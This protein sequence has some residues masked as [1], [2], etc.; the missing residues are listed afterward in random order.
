MEVFFE[1]AIGL[2]DN[3]SN[4]NEDKRSAVP[5][6]M[7]NKIGKLTIP[8]TK[9]ETGVNELTTAASL[10]LVSQEVYQDAAKIIEPKLDNTQC[11]FRR[12]CST[13]DQSFTLQNIFEKS[14]EY[15]KDVCKC[16]VDLGKVYSRVPREKLWGM[17]GVFSSGHRLIWWGGDAI[18]IC[19]EPNGS[20]DY[21][22]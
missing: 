5:A 2:P 19:N 18:S 13:T 11:G 14:W 17:L 10:C 12:G 6:R 3:A 16:F 21:M 4:Y 7:R 9:S 15:A 8:Y 22:V 20:Q 1:A